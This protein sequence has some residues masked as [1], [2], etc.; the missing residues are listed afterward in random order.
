VAKENLDM[1]D[2]TLCSFLLFLIR[3]LTTNK[4]KKKKKIKEGKRPHRI[5]LLHMGFPWQAE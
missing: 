3:L 1:N 2:Q 4:K 5:W